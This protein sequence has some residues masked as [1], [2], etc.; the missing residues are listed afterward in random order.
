MEAANSKIEAKINFCNLCVKQF[1]NL[2]INTDERLLAANIESKNYNDIA[3]AIK[4]EIVNRYQFFWQQ[5]EELSEEEDKRVLEYSTE[6][7]VILREKG[8]ALISK[9]NEKSRI[10]WGCKPVGRKT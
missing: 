7:A 8:N 4:L 2:A 1:K 10:K 3:E 5:A 9:L 6:L